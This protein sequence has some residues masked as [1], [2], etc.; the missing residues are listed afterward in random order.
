VHMARLVQSLL[1]LSTAGGRV[2]SRTRVDVTR[3]AREL[4]ESLREPGRDVEF[5]VE[6]GLA[7]D[8]DPYLLR[9]AL[10]NLL[11]NAV[12]F[13]RTKPRAVIEVGSEDTEHGRALFVRDNG[14]GFEPA[15]GQ[16]QLFQPFVRL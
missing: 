13:T 10:T 7:A 8:A 15:R 2:P 9:I 12:K 16:S 4:A 11:A 5:R 1:D 3:M 14:V 6:G